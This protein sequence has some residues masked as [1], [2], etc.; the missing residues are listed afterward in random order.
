MRTLTAALTA[1]GVTAALAGTPTA[2]AAPQ[3]D[4]KLPSQ[5]AKS[6]TV[7]KINRHLIA[8]QRIA[9]ANGGTRASG[10]PGFDAS[11]DYVA[12]KAEDAGFNVTRQP[13][14]FTYY[15]VDKQSL[16]SG[17]TT[18]DPIAMEYSP[19]TPAGGITAPT[20]AVPVDDTT[21]CEA[22]DYDGLDVT[23]K[24]ALISR[25]G[26]TF[27]AK[28]AAAA[29][30]GAAAAV[31]YNNTDGSLNG[32]LGE[33]GAIPSVGVSKDEGAKLVAN[34]GDDATLEVQA[35]QEERQTENVIAQTKTG[36]Q[37][38][39]V[40]I[41][42][43]LDSVP[44]GPGINDDGSGSANE[45]ALAQALGGSPKVNNAVRFSWWGAEESGLLGST[46]YVDSLSFDQQLDIALYENFDMIASPNAAYFVYDGDG[47]GFGTPGPYGSDKIE[48]AL[49][50]Q[51]TAQGVETEPTPFDGRSDY[52][53]F[54]NVG[55]PAGGTFT[56]AEGIMT[57]AQAAKWNG[58]AG[59]AYDKCYHQA[60]D[61]L[62][63]I[64][65]TALDR[66][67]NAIAYVT[68]Q[69]AL[70]TEDINGVGPAEAKSAATIKAQ[71]A[72]KT[73]LAKSTTAHGEYAAR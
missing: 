47:K 50:D 5:L 35:T 38:N 29:D 52:G 45:L 61:N 73:R 67:S 64:N 53:E 15:H 70:S 30:A 32:T 71:R 26:C 17:G 46:H 14:T 34:A 40:Q 59:V 11:A 16:T 27:F 62:G 51:F 10:T 39:V 49:A 65:R 42:S 25:G 21:G 28:Q 41:G 12:K 72:T 57:D 13:F 58:Q 54:I 48:K 9:D 69:Y 20:A 33:K 24:I 55:I 7:D 6:V 36:R 60:C 3:A 18:Y 43:H 4:A 22:S 1:A 68:G 2:M 66:N 56:G 31:I 23:G 44:E 19:S 37:D 63:N 8:L